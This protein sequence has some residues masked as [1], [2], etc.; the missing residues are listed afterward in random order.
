[1]QDPDSIMK[2]K[3]RTSWIVFRGS[4]LCMSF[5]CRECKPCSK[6]IGEIEGDYLVFEKST[7][8]CER[9]ISEQY[10]PSDQ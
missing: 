5:P 2:K 3:K 7:R 9:R 10:F 1:M 4:G 8:L 6:V